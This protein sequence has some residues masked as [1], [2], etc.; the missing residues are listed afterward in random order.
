MYKAAFL[1]FSGLFFGQLAHAQVDSTWAASDT[2][3]ATITAPFG[4]RKAGLSTA[5][6]R[7]L[8][9]PTAAMA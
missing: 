1:L 5:I 7:R 9:P 2:L 8:L 6:V 3:E 4:L